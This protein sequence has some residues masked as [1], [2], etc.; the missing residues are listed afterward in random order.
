M[1]TE[2]FTEQP[3]DKPL[4][5]RNKTCVYCGRQ[6]DT[7][8]RKTKEHVIARNFVP[9]GSL[10]GQWNLIVWACG[11]CNGVKSDLE[12]DLSAITLLPSLTGQIDTVD[13]TV[14]EDAIRKATGA[15]SRRTRKPVKD[16]QEQIEI[17]IPHG[18]MQFT[19]NMTGPPQADSNRVFRLA[20]HHVQA[21]FYLI[22]YRQDAQTGERMPG[23]FVPV[24]D[25]RRTDWGNP[26]M[27]GFMSATRNWRRRV[28]AI[29]ADQFFKLSIRRHPENAPLWAWAVEWNRNFRV[30]GF[31]GEQ[32]LVKSAI[33]VLP[34]LRAHGTSMED[35]S[36]IRYRV[37]EALPDSEDHLFFDDDLDPVVRST[38]DNQS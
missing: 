20:M 16:S 27:R 33:D 4:R 15:V 2:T 18:P 8:L 38:D 31:F 13:K 24:M 30:V 26:V 1:L 7:S 17:K 34:R 10:N 23:A 37:E 28:M 32:A 5:L 25:V 6:F 21:F 14:L 12:T 3:I 35:G 19:F 36:W 29:A 22:T 11:Q 9:R